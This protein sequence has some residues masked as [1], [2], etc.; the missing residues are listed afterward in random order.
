MPH[1]SLPKCPLTKK[2]EE[3]RKLL[4]DLRGRF[5]FSSRVFSESG[6]SGIMLLSRSSSL[7]GVAVLTKSRNKNVR[8]IFAVWEQA[9]NETTTKLTKHYTYVYIIL[10]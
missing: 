6:V 3:H 5:L 9:V 2:D 10:I 8:L 7:E 4:L 1:R